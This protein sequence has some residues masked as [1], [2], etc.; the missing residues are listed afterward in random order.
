MFPPF[1]SIDWLIPG[2]FIRCSIIG[3]ICG[4]TTVWF[5]LPLAPWQVSVLVG[6]LIYILD[7]L[8]PSLN[9]R[10][11][12]GKARILDWENEVVVVTGG[13]SGLGRVIVDTYRMRGV[14]VAAL[15]VNPFKAESDEG[16]ESLKF[17]QC[18]VGDMDAVQRAMQMIERELGT[19]TIL[20]NNAGIVNGKPLLSLDPQAIKRNFNV[21]LISHFYTIQAFLPAMLQRPGGGTV[22]TISSVLGQLGASHLS[23]YTA[24]KAG[25]IAMHTSLKQEIA[26]MPDSLDAPLGAQNIRTILVKPGQLS[27]PLF[28]GVET[29]SSFFGPVVPPVYLAKKIVEMIDSGKN[30]VIAEPL[31]ARYIEW[32]GVL[33]CGLQ[34]IA[35]WASGVD[36]AMSGF[37]KR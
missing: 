21:N 3:F 17:Y 32:M 19:P 24:A 33:P 27:T 9:E 10:I 18:D 37:G 20:I 29:P 5:N 25:L 36:K 28:E 4:T 16:M 14:R 15:D 12:W 31:Y 11:A 13:S 8:L 30:G 22:V 26:A 2:R 23:D 35:R 7:D 34:R 1:P 6:A